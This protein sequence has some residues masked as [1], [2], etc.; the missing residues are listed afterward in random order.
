M[1][2]ASLPKELEDFLVAIKGDEALAERL[3]LLCAMPR[4][5][6][7][8]EIETMLFAGH[9]DEAMRVA[10]R[11]L[12]DDTAASAARAYLRAPGRGIR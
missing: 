5:Q 10:L 3:L 12:E 9:G 6:R 2:V 4:G 11:R 7:L 8:V 1:S